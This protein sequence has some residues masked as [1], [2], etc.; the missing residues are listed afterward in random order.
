M[1]ASNK[2]YEDVVGVLLKKCA[3]PTLTANI[4]GTT[5]TAFDFASS[6]KIKEMLSNVALC[7]L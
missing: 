2:G 1:I 6:Q 3:D 4:K 5:V 7:A